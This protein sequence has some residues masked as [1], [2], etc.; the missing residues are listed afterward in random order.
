ML[1]ASWRV[2][3]DLDRGRLWIRV[4]ER[5]AR[6]LHIAVDR[7]LLAQVRV[8]LGDHRKKAPSGLSLSGRVYAAVAIWLYRACLRFSSP[9]FG[10]KSLVMRNL[11]MLLMH[12]SGRCTIEAKQLIEESR[13]PIARRDSS[14]EYSRS[15]IHEAF[16]LMYEG[17]FKEAEEVLNETYRYYRDDSKYLV[18]Q[19]LTRYAQALCF[20]AQSKRDEA[21]L[22]VKMHDELRRRPDA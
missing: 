19:A 8:W 11:A 2:L 10:W 21:A 5:P 1:L 12:R 14:E 17:A 20:A 3:T 13:G 18:G 16:R 15:G 22:A 6:L 9:A 4:L 7:Q